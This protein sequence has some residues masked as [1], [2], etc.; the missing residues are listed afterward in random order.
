MKK[1]LLLAFFSFATIAIN[2]QEISEE[3]WAL[4][5]KK[6]ADWCPLCGQ[7]GWTFKNYLLE[8]YAE[9][10]VIFWMAHYSGDLMTPTAKA[11][12]DN[13]GSS[14]QPIF[15]VNNDNMGVGSSNL[16]A[17]RDEVAIVVDFLLGQLPFAG[18]GTTATFDGEKITTTSRAKFLLNLEGGE[19]WLASYLVD[20]ELIAPQASQGSTA[21]HE[22]ILLHAFS[23]TDYFGENITSGSVAANE[24]FTIEGELDFSGEENIPDYADGYSVV[25]VLWGVA[26]GKFT[27][28]NLN[29]QPVTASVST[30]DILNNV[31]ITAFHLG[32]GQVSLNITSAQ[33]IDNASIQLFNINGQVVATKN[34]IN[35]T[36]G[37]NQVVVEAQDLAMGTYIAVVESEIGSRSIK[38]SVR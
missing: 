16:N 17:K 38:V 33:K 35:I 28:I 2:A 5:T 1:L 36:S 12:T 22:N 13:L 20:D 8:D 6:T 18:V 4:I 14:G 19:Y 31:D 32:A 3:Q 23:G 10:P 21:V 37:E 9:E 29:R 7:F 27:P 15:F 34:N 25:T 11:I 30:K 26:G 24:E